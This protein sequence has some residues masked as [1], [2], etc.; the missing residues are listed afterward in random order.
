[1]AAEILV[2]T[3][4]R[5]SRE[6][7]CS[8]LDRC[9]SVRDTQLLSWDIPSY[10]ATL[11]LSCVSSFCFPNLTSSSFLIANSFL[12][13]DLLE[14]FCNFCLFSLALPPGRFLYLLLIFF[15]LLLC[16]TIQEVFFIFFECFFH[17]SLSLF[18]QIFF[19]ALSLFP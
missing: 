11:L 15:F 8:N 18:Q 14:Q 1:M 10:L 4:F 7:H 2:V 3:A 5:M 19:V 6:L 13:L 17:N 12:M 16:F 9:P